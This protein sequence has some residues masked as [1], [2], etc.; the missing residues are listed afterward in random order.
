MAL[1]KVTKSARAERLARYSR[2]SRGFRREACAARRPNPKLYLAQVVQIDYVTPM[3]A[4][5]SRPEN[6]SR[7]IAGFPKDY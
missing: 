3:Y 5:K 2:N 6:F 7:K 4:E 1:A